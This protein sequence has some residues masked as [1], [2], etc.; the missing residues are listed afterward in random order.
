MQSN[1]L[2][3]RCGGIGIRICV[4]G[5]TIIMSAV[6]E[7]GSRLEEPES[8]CSGAET[9][10]NGWDVEGLFM[11][12]PFQSARH[13][14]KAYHKKF[15]NANHLF[16]FS[17]VSANSPGSGILILMPEELAPKPVDLCLVA[18]A[19]LREAKTG[20]LPQEFT[21]YANAQAMAFLLRL[22]LGPEL[23]A[24]VERARDLKGGGPP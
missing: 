17:S 18:D 8:E 2:P 14:P 6:N 15:V 5:P 10:A 21:Q 20:R 4:I 13:S 19:V 24:M 22:G 23:N 11:R 9:L 7:T 16:R 3:T 12:D 1:F